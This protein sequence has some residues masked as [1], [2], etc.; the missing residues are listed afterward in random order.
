MLLGGCLLMSPYPL[1]PYSLA[2]VYPA[3]PGEGAGQVTSAVRTEPEPPAPCSAI[4]GLLCY[5]GDNDSDDDAIG[6]SRS[7]DEGCVSGD[8]PTPVNL[9][10]AEIE[11]K[12]GNR[13]YAIP[14]TGVRKGGTLSWKFVLSTS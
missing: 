11:C 9:S 7:G 14:L 12:V 13:V 4:A 5:G 10:V 6:C 8:S 3:L 1:T 2:T